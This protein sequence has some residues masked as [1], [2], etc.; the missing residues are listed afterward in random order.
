MTPVRNGWRYWLW[1]WTHLHTCHFHQVKEAE[2]ADRWACGETAAWT[3]PL[4]QCCQCGRVG[5]PT[6]GLYS[7]RQP[8][9]SS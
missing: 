9:C 2:I 1:Y 8:P 4:Y 3:E 6:Y 7:Q 5:A